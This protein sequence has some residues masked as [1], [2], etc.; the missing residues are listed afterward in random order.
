MNSKS[1]MCP[2]FSSQYFNEQSTYQV[3]VGGLPLDAKDQEM[4][5]EFSKTFGQIADARIMRF[6]DGRSRGFG[7]VQFVSFNQYIQ[8]LGSC[9]VRLNGHQIECRPSMTPDEAAKGARE[10]LKRK[11]ILYGITDQA[12]QDE[13]SSYFQG[14]A[15]VVR[16]KFFKN[17]KNIFG[18]GQGYIEFSSPASI[19]QIVNN[20]QLPRII[21]VAGKPLLVYSA[22]A[23]SSNTKSWKDAFK[24]TY[25]RKNMLIPGFPSAKSIVRSQET[26]DE[27]RSHNSRSVSPIK[28]SASGAQR[29]CTIRPSLFQKQLQQGDQNMRFNLPQA[30]LG[31]ILSLKIGCR[32]HTLISKMSQ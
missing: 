27:Y 19:F 24:S 16:A 25:A 14:T 3:F 5:A 26:A 20:A 31:P 1:K 28:L 2:Q 23:K 8:A 18:F 21:E 30:K 11:L 15:E 10:L 6:R 32:N 9:K 12:F 22:E 29:V 13:I 17:S 4:F 7:F